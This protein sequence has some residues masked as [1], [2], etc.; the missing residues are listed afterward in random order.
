MLCNS[1]SPQF[2]IVLVHPEIAGNTGSIGRTCLALQAELILIHPL[3]FSLD[4]K[5]V[6]RAGLDYWKHV[7]LREYPS[8]QNFINDRKPLLNN[9]FFIETNSSQTIFNAKFSNN[10]YLIFGSETKG[11]PLD[12]TM[13]Y[14]ANNFYELPMFS[15]KI[16]SL[17]LSNAVT[18]CSYEVIRQ[19]C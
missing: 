12:L 4:E 10:S 14:P 7:S 2:H 16:R 19:L 1:I 3:G 5:K 13:K 6:R 9:L 8:W 15:D 18:A 11:L 17:N